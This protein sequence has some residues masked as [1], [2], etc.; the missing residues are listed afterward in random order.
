MDRQELR[1]NPG[2]SSGAVPVPNAVFDHLMP[3]LGDTE[4][5]VYLVVLR[6]TIGWSHGGNAPK[7]RDWLSSSQLMRRTGRGSEAVSKA[8]D[9]LV[10]RGLIRVEDVGGNELPTP[11]ARRNHSGGLHF[12]LAVRAACRNVDKAAAFP[13]SKNEYYNK[14]AIQQ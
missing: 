5:R 14:Q 6:Q 11:Q 7:R 9:A 10:R 1:D 12:S 8:I 4:L 13:I 2:F 3:T